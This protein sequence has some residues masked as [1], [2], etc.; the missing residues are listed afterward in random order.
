MQQ[1]N[2]LMHPYLSCQTNVVRENRSRAF[3]P[4]SAQFGILWN[5]HLQL[6][7]C[8][9]LINLCCVN[10]QVKIQAHHLLF[11]QSFE[12]RLLRQLAFAASR[13]FGH[14]AAQVRRHS[15]KITFAVLRY[16]LQALVVQ[17]RQVA[18]EVE[19]RAAEAPLFVT[20]ALQ[21]FHIRRSGHDQ[22]KPQPLSHHQIDL[23]ENGCSGN[24]TET[25]QA[26][27]AHL[28]VYHSRLRQL[29]REECVNLWVAKKKHPPGDRIEEL[30]LW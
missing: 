4:H 22:S 13:F 30:L 19:Q 9:R 12:G 6:M 16:H 8:N 26:L 28:N 29:H 20:V 14:G 15:R 7:I 23:E 18:L 24:T 17:C 27:D 5:L 2:L 10:A 11:L 21:R 1:Q 3:F 25:R